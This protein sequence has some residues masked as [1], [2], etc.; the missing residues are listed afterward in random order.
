MTDQPRN[1]LLAA[2]YAR[3]A[4]ELMQLRAHFT[5]QLMNVAAINVRSSAETADKTLQQGSGAMFEYE[6]EPVQ[7]FWPHLTL[8]DPP[9]TLSDMT[10]ELLSVKVN[11][12]TIE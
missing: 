5:R 7:Q 3:D 10:L 6:F 4:G 2:S 12:F 1:S 8:E 11:V 9:A